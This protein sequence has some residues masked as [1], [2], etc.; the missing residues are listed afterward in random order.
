MKKVSILFLVFVLLL[1]SGAKLAIVGGYYLN[2]EFIIQNFCENKAR[3]EMHCNGKCYL[4]KKI[5][6]HDAHENALAKLL[7]QIPE[8]TLSTVDID[9][10]ISMP[11]IRVLSSSFNLYTFSYSSLSGKSIF[12]PPKP[13]FV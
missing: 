1:Q 5:K 13:L 4:M 9:Y 2:Q 3:P 7:K 12:Q 8:V 11:V 6:H 10:L